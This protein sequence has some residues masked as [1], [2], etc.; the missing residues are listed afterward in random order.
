MNLFKNIICFSRTHVHSTIFSGHSF[1]TKKKKG[2]VIVIV[3]DKLIGLSGT[4]KTW[5]QYSCHF[6]VPYITKINDFIDIP[7]V[8]KY[9]YS[10]GHMHHLISRVIRYKK[11]Y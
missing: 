11:K 2:S 8:V 6:Y 10:M 7:L 3:I 1:A 4:V 9:Q 5:G